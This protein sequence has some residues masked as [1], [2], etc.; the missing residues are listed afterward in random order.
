MHQIGAL[1]AAFKECQSEEYRD[2]QRQVCKNAKA[3]GAV[4]TA[5]G[6][7]LVTGGTDNHLLLVNLKSSKV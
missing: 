1:A 6:C 7:D 3:L 4:L 5:G 2:Y